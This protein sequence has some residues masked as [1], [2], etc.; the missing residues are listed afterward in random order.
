MQ[1]IAFDAH[2][3]YTL[4]SVARPDG[5]LVT[6]RRVE[7]ER[8]ALRDFLDR[9]E[10]G[11]PVAVET[12]GN[13]YWIIDEIEAAGCIPK[14]VHARKA[15]L[16][17]GSINKTD[18]LDARGLNQLQRNGTLPTVWIPPGALRDQ[19][20][21]PRTRMV[22]V[23]QRAQLKNRIH[24]S[25]AK[26]AL[27]DRDM[28]DLFGVSGRA[29]LRQRLRL[30]PE[31]TA[32]AT[33]RLLEQ[34]ESLDRQVEAFEQRMMTVFKP[35]PAVQLLM[36]LPG[37]GF[38]LAVLIALEVG[39]VT[40][41]AT[42]EKLAAYA[43]TTPR[44]HSSGGKTRYGHLRPDVNRYLKW[45]FVE[46]AN[47]ICIGRRRAPHRHVSRLYERVAR[48]K[49]HPKA[50]GAVARHLAEATYWMLRKQEP[51]QPPQAAAVSS[52]RDKRG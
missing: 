6:E 50:I 37:V 10:P 41:F 12:V 43:G 19:R 30:L 34:V 36:T 7:H 20:D 31:H 33:E 52:T 22:L 17:M 4:A 23:R 5:Q 1:Y 15:K 29:L 27:H 24:A 9:C 21:L 26:Y 8:G 48:R 28:S 40:R 38:L 11:S 16:M 39:D 45:A 46:A 51:Y 47:V 2:K 42:A 13:W 14:L 18:R 25:L 49:G 44:V 32:Y 35:T 3:H